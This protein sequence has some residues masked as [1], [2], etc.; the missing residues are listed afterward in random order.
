[1]LVEG[2]SQ[3]YQ[4]VTYATPTN[5]HRRHRPCRY[6]R[7]RGRAVPLQP[8]EKI[9]W[10]GSEGT[11][12]SRAGG[13]FS[14]A[15]AGSPANGPLDTSFGTGGR[16]RVEFFAPPMQGAQEFAGAVLVQPDGKIL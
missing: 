5:Y 11:P 14:S 16:A 8:H 15:V 3:R 7:G 13:P 12:G 4:E 9:I 6:G 2:A 10:V 1:M